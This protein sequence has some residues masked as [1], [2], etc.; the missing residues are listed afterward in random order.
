MDAEQVIAGD[1]A[2]LGYDPD[3]VP[4]SVKS[5]VV[6]MY[7]HIRDKN[8]YEI[9]QMYETS[10]QSISDRFFKDTPWPS[11]DSVAPY[12]DKDHVFGLLYREMWFRHVFARLSPTLKQRIDSWENYCNL[13]KVIMV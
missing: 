11:A 8:V 6:H 13:F 9:H 7:R 12:V 4:D 10:F 1:S 2:S 5:F 3:F